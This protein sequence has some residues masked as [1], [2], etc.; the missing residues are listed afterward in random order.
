M[1][2]SARYTPLITNARL[3]QPNN[4]QFHGWRVAKLQ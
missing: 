1:S 3:F 4:L 2:F